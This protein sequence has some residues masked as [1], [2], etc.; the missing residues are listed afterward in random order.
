MT[1]TGGTS[2]QGGTNTSTGGKSMTTTGGSKG[3]NGMLP[4]EVKCDETP[5]PKDAPALEA[6]KWTAI[7][8]EA[9][10][11]ADGPKFVGEPNSGAFVQGMAID[12]C[13][14]NTIY[15]TVQTFV[16]TGGGLYKTIDAGAHWTQVGNL[17]E[18][19]R[20][21][22]DPKNPLHLYAGDGVRG[23][24][25][26][27]WVSQDGGNT[28]AIP[29]GFTAL[30]PGTV[31][32]QDLYDVAVDPVDF[33]HV[34]VTYHS[35]WGGPKYGTASGVLESTDGGD[36][37]VANT[38]D[39][40]WG[41]GNNVW[42]MDNSATWLLGSQAAGYWRTTDSGAHWAQ[43]SKCPMTHGGGQLYKAGDA[44]YSSCNSGV[45]RS[46]DGGA[47][48]TT[49]LNMFPTTSVFGDGTNLYTHSAYLSGNGPFYS[50]PEADGVTWAPATDG[51][52]MFTDGPFEMAVDPKQH[53]LY[54]ANW[55]NGLLAMPIP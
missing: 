53:I 3:G 30:I 17:D 1:G 42:F 50:S 35:E 4:S 37:W 36:S 14:T 33:N 26:G 25:M 27:F 40:S 22:V 34:L 5:W 9:P 2:A 18:P 8:P 55:G 39:P 31:T 48:W 41:S 23:M 28:W 15:L 45:Q 46:T 19:I 43:V 12:P 7:N 32:N 16:S 38:P 6:G 51:S 29:A 13:N 49:V 44:W 21:R 24:T 52:Q 47:T 10:A 20:V 11:G 54:S